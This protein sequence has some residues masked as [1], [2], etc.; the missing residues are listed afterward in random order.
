MSNFVWRYRMN[1]YIEIY[2]GKGVSIMIN[3]FLKTETMTCRFFDRRRVR[4]LYITHSTSS[5][6]EARLVPVDESDNLKANI[7]Q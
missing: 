5:S 1:S 6:R 3:P 2:Q 7:V 4:T